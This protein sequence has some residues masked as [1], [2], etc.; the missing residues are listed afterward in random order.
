MSFQLSEKLY[1]LTDFVGHFVDKQ[2]KTMQGMKKFFVVQLP[3]QHDTL[4]C[5]VIALQNL[6]RKLKLKSS[7]PLFSYIQNG[8]L[9][10]LTTAKA[11]Y[12][13]VESISKCGY[14]PKDFDFHALLIVVLL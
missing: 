1:M 13:L 6:I 9:T 10:P 5:P 8:Q 11:S 7:Q 4:I 12:L 3:K 2:S 14:S